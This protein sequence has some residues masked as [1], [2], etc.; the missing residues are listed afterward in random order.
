MRP[1]TGLTHQL[2]VTL[3]ALGAPIVG[4]ERY[5]GADAGSNSSRLMLHAAGLML[6]KDL[7]VID[8]D[9][10]VWEKVRLRASHFGCALTLTKYGRHVCLLT[11]VASLITCPSA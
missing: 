10:E 11:F 2:R 8:E 5:G 9:C 7:G 1:M 6:S 4:D 3:N